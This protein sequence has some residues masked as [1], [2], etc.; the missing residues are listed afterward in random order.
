MFCL[1][2][3]SP[4]ATLQWCPQNT[5]PTHT[6]IHEPKR[7]E[8]EEEEDDHFGCGRPQLSVNKQA[9]PAPPLTCPARR[10]GLQINTSHIWK[11]AR[12]H[13]PWLPPLSLEEGSPPTPSRGSV[14]EHKP[15]PPPRSLPHLS[16]AHF[17][18]TLWTP[19][20]LVCITQGRTDS[21]PGPPG[22][23]SAPDLTPR[24]GPPAS[25]SRALLGG[26]GLRADRRRTRKAHRWSVKVP[27]A[28]GLEVRS[29]EEPRGA[30]RE[31][32]TSEPLDPG[33][34]LFLHPCPPPLLLSRS[35]LTGKN[36]E[37]VRLLGNFSILILFPR[38]TRP[39][40]SLFPKCAHS[41]T[42]S[43]ASPP[44]QFFPAAH[45]DGR[46]WVSTHERF[47]QG[48]RKSTAP[49]SPAWH[50]GEGACWGCPLV[51]QQFLENA[52]SE[53]GYSQIC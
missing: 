46:D 6:Y 41:K 29:Q 37:L 48:S 52:K 34:T 13:R 10:P 50:T 22:C 49:S 38:S 14:K 21:F 30:H 53:A 28:A 40:A 15:P 36:T 32:Q 3:L 51:T 26:S 9:H 5:P 19:G 16:P 45:Q 7:A 39:R 44:S 20:S 8:Q 25:R 12:P 31:T 11:Q 1:A 42:I 43:S 17:P 35:Q 24:S 18:G 4:L 27:P 33:P 23:M 2:L 47:S